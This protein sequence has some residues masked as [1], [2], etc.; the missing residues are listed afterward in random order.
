MLAFTGCHTTVPPVA[1]GPFHIAMVTFAGYAP[2]YLAKEKG[3]FGDLDVQLTRI[4]EIP[5]IRAAMA[6]KD[7]EAYLATP[8]IALDT[9]SAPPGRAIWA[10]DESAG[11]DGVIVGEGLGDNIAA[12][13]NRKVA[14]EPGLPPNFLLLYFLY[15]NGM[16]LKDVQYKD[17]STQNA[18]T[19]FVSRAVDAA[20]IY[21]PYLSQARDK[22]RGSKVVLSSKDLPGVIVDLIFAREELVTGEDGRIA[23]VI[24]GWRRAVR[25]IRESP[26]D[27]YPIMAKAFNTPVDQFKDTVS[28]IR[29][30]D[31]SDNQRLFGTKEHPGPLPGAFSEVNQVLQKNRPDT[32]HAEPAD[33]LVRT[34]IE[35]QK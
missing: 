25:F 17:M 10:I 34:Y 23:K 35:K 6:R 32:Y 24:D 8:D 1:T 19:A 5:S 22:R 30:L 26:N 27:A 4:E 15:K 14:A 9:N 31:L 2:L 18:E 13:K 11:G 20:G 7:V 3:F 21:E 33:Y 12:L 28:G 16:T 29:W